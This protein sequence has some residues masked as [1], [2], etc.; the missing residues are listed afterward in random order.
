MSLQFNFAAEN[1]I[2]SA[3]AVPLYS[4][5]CQLNGQIYDDDDEEDEVDGHTIQ[6]SR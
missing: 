1:D 2:T 5:C 4:R 3:Y 6:W